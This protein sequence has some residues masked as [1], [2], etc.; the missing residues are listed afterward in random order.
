M[1]DADAVVRAGLHLTASGLEG[2]GENLPQRSAVF[3]DIILRG[4][5]QVMFQCNSYA[6]LLFL[7]G[8]AVN[9]LLFAAGALLGTITATLAAIGFGMDRALV[10]S[11][12][13]GFNG[14]LVAI[15]LLYFLAPGPLTWGCVIL[16]AACSALVMAA[17]LQLLNIWQMPALTAPFVL[18]SFVFFL[19]TARF[20]RLETTGELP[21]A[22]LPVQAMVEGVVTAATVSEGLFTG[23]GQVFFQGNM[24]SGALFALGLGIASRRACMMA[25][26]G[27]LAGVLVAWGMGAAEPSIRAG[28]FG[29]NS[30]LTAIAIGSV[31]LMPGRASAIYAIIGAIITPFVAA[32]CAAALEPLG[33]PAMTLP[34][35]LCTWVLLWASRGS[36]RLKPG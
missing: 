7:A 34:F 23:I 33:L 16:A 31:F 11:G 20:G 35:V 12:L 28:A 4:L 1:V 25:I 29:F 2:E 21:T 32:A 24:L 5:G 13:F 26:M 36:G 9:S 27:S 8:I 3:A 14:A 15:A 6:G 10:R 18:T 30:V 17:M 19:A 22:G